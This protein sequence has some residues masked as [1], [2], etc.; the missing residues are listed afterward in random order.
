MSVAF[1]SVA[2]EFN[3]HNTLINNNNNNNDVEIA[4]LASKKLSV[5]DN[6]VGLNNGHPPPVINVNGAE[7]QQQNGI[8]ENGTTE[9]KKQLLPPGMIGSNAELL[10]L[11]GS[12]INSKSPAA[13]NGKEMAQKQG[14]HNF[15][16]CF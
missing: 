7:L 9:A 16:S 6:N 8:T 4:S 2:V 15:K 11:N 5:A 3:S 13:Q 12:T 1:D 14:K 10:K